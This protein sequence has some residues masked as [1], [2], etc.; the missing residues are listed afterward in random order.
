[1]TYSGLSH[2]VCV[3]IV[4]IYISALSSSHISGVLVGDWCNGVLNSYCFDDLYHFASMCVCVYTNKNSF[5][6][7]FFFAEKAC[8]PV[9]YKPWK[10]LAFVYVSVHVSRLKV[11]QR[12]PFAHSELREQLPCVRER[13][14][15]EARRL[16]I[17]KR[18]VS[19]SQTFSHVLLNPFSGQNKGLEKLEAENENRMKSLAHD[20]GSSDAS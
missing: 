14:G 2:P 13:Y 12:N 6:S 3:Y 8:S 10:V 4:F 11:T 7:L 20:T 1:M 9:G 5:I 19:Y 18:H 15:T 17:V 16:C